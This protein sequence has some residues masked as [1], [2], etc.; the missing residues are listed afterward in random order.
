M[1][2]WAEGRRTHLADA[3]K[4]AAILLEGEGLLA[5]IFMS[6]VFTAWTGGQGTGGTGLVAEQE[7]S[8]S[9]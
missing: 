2:G 4:A 7:T 3:P 9:S 1:Q 5:L 8:S 6:L